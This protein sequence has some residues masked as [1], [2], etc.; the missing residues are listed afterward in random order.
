MSSASDRFVRQE[1]LVPRDRLLGLWAT[2]IGVGAVGRQIALQLAAIG[3]PRLQLID[4]DRVDETNITTQGFAAADVGRP[5][6][7]ATGEA[8]TRLDPAIAVETVEDRFRPKY[9]TGAAIF[10]C[11]DSI[12]ARAAIWRAVSSRCQFWCD[13][14]MLSEVI[15][16]LAVDERVGREHYGTTLFAQQEAQA[17]R[18]TARSTIYS[19]NIAA[20]LMIHQFTRWLRGLPIDQDMSLNLL[21]SELSVA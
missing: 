21:S 4:F 13:G 7:E 9:A 18:C 20:G 1:E 16:V 15:R 3:V 8:V 11:V 12:S 19:A 17:G 6:I 14:R 10:C 5:K 2:V